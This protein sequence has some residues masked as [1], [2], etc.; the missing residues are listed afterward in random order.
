MK[1]KAIKILEDIIC[2]A[3]HLKDLIETN[4]VDVDETIIDQLKSANQELPNP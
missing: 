2:Q 3:K 1:D 4:N